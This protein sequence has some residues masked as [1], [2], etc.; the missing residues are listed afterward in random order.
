MPV[1]VRNARKV[2]KKCPRCSNVV[3]MHLI[4]NEDFG[5]GLLAKLRVDFFGAKS[6]FNFR[7]KCPICIYEEPLTVQQGYSLME[8]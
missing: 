2:R 3:D 4:R 5:F 6:Y 7:L 8:R 1:P